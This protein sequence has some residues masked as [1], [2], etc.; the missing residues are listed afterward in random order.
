VEDQTSAAHFVLN[1]RQPLPGST[2]GAAPL[3]FRAAAAKNPGVFLA[4]ESSCSLLRIA[5]AILSSPLP[6]WERIEGEGPNS[7]RGDG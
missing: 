5:S 7:A 2:D 1:R 6:E 3:S 4:I